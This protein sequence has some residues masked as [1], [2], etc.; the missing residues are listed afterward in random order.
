MKRHLLKSHV[1]I[2]EYAKRK[3]IYPARV[4]EAI[5]AGKIIPDYIGQSGIRM[6][7][8]K[9]YDSYHF[10]EKNVAK[11]TVRQW[12]ERKGRPKAGTNNDT[13]N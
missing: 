4:Y 13:K 5:R 8:L 12:F 7:D 2:T 3:E 6:L 1:T 10:N 11:E 9:K